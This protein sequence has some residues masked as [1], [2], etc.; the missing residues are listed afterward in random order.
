MASNVCGP[1]QAMCHMLGVWNVINRGFKQ[2]E[3]RTEEKEGKKRKERERN[4][5]K[6]GRKERRKGTGTNVVQGVE[7]DGK[8]PGT[9][10]REVGF[11]LLRLFYA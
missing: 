2:V 10:L 3:S 1:W 11:L 8:G 6:E 7:S 4:E 9:V 5:R